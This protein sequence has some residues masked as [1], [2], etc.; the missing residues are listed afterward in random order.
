MTL[1]GRKTTSNKAVQI[2]KLSFSEV[3]GNISIYAQI[4]YLFDAHCCYNIIFDADFLDINYNNNILQWMDHKIPLKNPDEFFTNNMPFDL[5]DD[6]CLT[7]E[8]NMFDWEILNNY[9]KQILD[10][11]YKQIDTNKITFN[12]K[13]INITQHHNAKHLLTNDKKIIQLVSWCLSPP[14]VHID[15]LPGFKLVHH[16]VYPFP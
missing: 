8:E 13:H 1:L 10:A 2:E 16:R 6:I 14:K 4:A 9:A 12:Q 3:N 7:K 11:K 5:N 15:L